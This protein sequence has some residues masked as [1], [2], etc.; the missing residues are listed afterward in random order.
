MYKCPHGSVVKW[1]MRV[2]FSFFL[3]SFETFL[4]SVLLV[5]NAKSL[6]EEISRLTSAG[7]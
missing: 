2:F 6:T 4:F 3:S 5:D 7:E 1:R